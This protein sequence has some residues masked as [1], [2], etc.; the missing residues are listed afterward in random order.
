ML[1][2]PSGGQQPGSGQGR[3]GHGANPFDL[4]DS[5]M[6][7]M[8]GSMQMMQQMMGGMG[9]MDPFG[10]PPSGARGGGGGGCF[11]SSSCCYSS[12]SN[13]NGGPPR[14]VQY[15]SS[16]HGMQRPG[17]EMVREETRNYR[18]SSGTEK[19]GVSRTI[20]NRG[21]SIAAERH[22]DGTERR[23]DNVRG[24]S[25]G[26]AFDQEWNS[27]G[28]VQA[29]TR[30]RDSVR[31]LGADD[32]MAPLAGGSLR[33]PTLTSED[34][35]AARQGR[36]NYEAQRDKMIAEARQGR[37][38][39]ASQAQPAGGHSSRQMVPRYAGHQSLAMREPRR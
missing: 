20:G 19:T 1:Y 8:M 18:D 16:S 36:L 27:H 3:R 13:P 11:S 23:T 2:R 10:M 17:E 7:Q 24:I 25:N 30:N 14:V 32:F 26:T 22:S 33:Q 37:Q 35:E 12:S 29:M 5:H 38:G 28:T 4:V 9:G 34:R 31:R 39:Q 15:Q 21:R 6:S